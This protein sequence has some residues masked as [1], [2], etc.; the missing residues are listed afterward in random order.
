MEERGYREDLK[1]LG[2]TAQK[3][4]RAWKSECR[5]VGIQ[6]PPSNNLFKKTNKSSNFDLKCFN[7][8]VKELIFGIL[9]PKRTAGAQKKG[10]K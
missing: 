7:L 1:Y 4:W 10:F 3:K 8:E 9:R 5:Q 2:S 6:I